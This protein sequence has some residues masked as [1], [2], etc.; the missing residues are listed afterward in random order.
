MNC[1]LAAATY[2]TWGFELMLA[3]GG[4]L[5]FFLFLRE[6][7]WFYWGREISILERMTKQ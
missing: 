1:E 2:V 7:L 4:A 5:G 6:C 3:G